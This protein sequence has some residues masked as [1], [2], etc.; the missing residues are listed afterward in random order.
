MF[1]YFFYET[2]GKIEMKKLKNIFNLGIKE[3]LSLKSDKVLIIFLVYGFTILVYTAAKNAGLELRNASVAIADEDQS[4]L[5]NRIQDAFLKP[6]FLPPEVI[7]VRDIDHLMNSGLYTFVIDIPPDFQKDIVGGDDPTIQVNVDA[8]AISQ[9]AIGSGYIRNIINGEIND[10]MRDYGFK[11]DP[12]PTSL[13]I[14]IK[15][16]PNLQGHWFMSVMEM[17]NIMTLIAILTSGA[18][19]IREREKETIDHLLVMPLT[20]FEI[21]SAKFWSNA[22]VMIIAVL[23]CLTF[24]IQFLLNVQIQGS[25]LIFTAGVVLYLFSMTSIGIFLAT[26]ARSMQQLGLLSILVV[27]PMLLLSGGYTPLDAMPDIIDY[28]TT[29][30]P[31]RHFVSFA[32]AVLFRG[33]GLGIVWPQFLGVAV[34]GSLFFIGALLRFRS[35]ITSSQS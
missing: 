12:I 7:K 18:A 10:F 4:A 34:I 26:I 16:N 17:I 9:A 3:L 8:T 1:Q 24:I 23:F 21:M 11:N 30:S 6:Y 22:L 25:I 2:A 33:A 14:K 13:D 32:Q 27:F 35:T 15:F 19:V 29:L 28:M 5:S 20:P 31:T